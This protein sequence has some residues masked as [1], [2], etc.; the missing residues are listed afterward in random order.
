MSDEFNQPD[1]LPPL[2]PSTE[3]AWL[4]AERESFEAAQRQAES[5]Q[6]TEVAYVIADDGREVLSE[7]AGAY[8]SF[9]SDSGCTDPGCVVDW[10]DKNSAAFEKALERH[11]RDEGLEFAK[12]SMIGAGVNPQDAAAAIQWFVAAVE[13]GVFD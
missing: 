12:D 5:A 11:G 10:W 1:E 4:S 6:D 2:N 13:K 9:V 8:K 7:N 3:P